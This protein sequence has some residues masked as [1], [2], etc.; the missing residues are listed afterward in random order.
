M[1]AIAIFSDR[2]DL[3]GAIRRAVDP[4]VKNFTANPILMRKTGIEGYASLARQVLATAASF[5]IAPGCAR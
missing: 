1:S 5:E 2:A 3:S 4:F